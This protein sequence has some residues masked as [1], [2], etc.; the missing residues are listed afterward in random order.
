M[1]WIQFDAD[2]PNQ[3][4]IDKIKEI[5]RS[6]LSKVESL[7]KT[8]TTKVVAIDIFRPNEFDSLTENDVSL[9]ELSNWLLQQSIDWESGSKTL[10][11]AIDKKYKTI[12]NK[13]IAGGR[14][15]VILDNLVE[16]R[17]KRVAIEVET[18]K[19]LDNGYFSLRQAIKEKIADYGV[20]IVP[21]FELGSGRAN[22]GKALG[23]LDREFDGKTDLQEAPIFRIVPIR[24]IDSL[25]VIEN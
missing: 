16:I 6:Y 25:K 12:D 4:K 17:G 1:N 8:I 7:D 19:N 10:Q 3:K 23:R 18:S 2:K 24:I 15:Y 11:R 21:W 13:K 14:E 22:E 9:Q 20:M 5:G